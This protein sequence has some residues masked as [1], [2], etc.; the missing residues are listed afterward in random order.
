MLL[1]GHGPLL[2]G[3]LSD[4]LRGPFGDESLRYAILVATAAYFWAG[5][6]FILAG[7]SIRQALAENSAAQE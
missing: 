7:R 1:P 3:V 4:L 5:A 2:V 6:H